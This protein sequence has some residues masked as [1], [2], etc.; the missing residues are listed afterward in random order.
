MK[1]AFLIL[2]HK[3]PEQLD[4]LIEIMSIDEFTFFVHLDKKIKYKSFEFVS[5]RSNVIFIKDR[6]EVT[7]GSFSMT[8]A[9][10]KSYREIL[11][12]DEY[13]Y[14]NVITSQHLPIKSS[15]KL[16]KHLSENNG[17]QFINA[18]K[19]NT[20]NPWW[21]RCEIR[22]LTYSFAI[23][24]IIGKYR[25]ESIVNKIITKR[26]LPSNYIIAG[27]PSYFFLTSECVEYI[28]NEF[29]VKRKLINFFKYVWGPDEF[30][31]ATIIFNS[32]FKN[33]I[34]D[35]LAYVEFLGDNQGHSKVMV[36]TDFEKLK[37]STK[38]FA[39]KFDPYVDSEI[40]TMINKFRNGDVE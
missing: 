22:I 39:K 40:I 9:I 4:K 35:C 5:A 27:G 36:K 37:N 13:D 30:I 15:Q 7:W 3:Y 29:N 6:V 32:K 11:M 31:F 38:F 18:I 20:E 28:V 19:Y 12:H 23:W 33:N 10:V 8:E 34:K 25:I 26:K 21:K 17:H 16:L 1:V 2:S 24:K 14:I